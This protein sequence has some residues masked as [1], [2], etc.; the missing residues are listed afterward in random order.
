MDLKTT[1]LKYGLLLAAISIAIALISFYVFPLGIWTQSAVSLLLYIVFMVWAAKEQRT[2]NGGF[3]SFGD[4]FKT[5][6]FTGLVGSVIS[7]FFT[8]IWMNLIDTSL[9]EK[10]AEMALDS[11]RSMLEKFG[12]DENTIAEA[13]EKAEE[14]MEDKFTPLNYILQGL[15]GIIMGLIPSAIIALIMKKEEKI[16]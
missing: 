2:Q 3:I 13:I 10:M 11:T 6:F 5:V 9:S 8:L 12:A 4:A 15:Q 7:L 1:W 16:A 14:E